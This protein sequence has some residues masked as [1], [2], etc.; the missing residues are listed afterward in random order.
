MTKIRARLAVEYT[1]AT[2]RGSA[3]AVAPEM[4]A[5]SVSKGQ[6]THSWHLRQ[7]FLKSEWRGVCVC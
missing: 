7:G 6:Q 4:A 3:P 1:N 2:A 5:D